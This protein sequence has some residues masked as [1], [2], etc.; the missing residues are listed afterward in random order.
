MLQGYGDVGRYSDIR[1]CGDIEDMVMLGGY[2]GFRG[3]SDFFFF[4]RFSSEG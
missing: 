1:G 3:Y 2:G 4:F